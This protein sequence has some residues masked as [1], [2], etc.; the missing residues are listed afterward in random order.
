MGVYDRQVASTLRKLAAKGQLVTWVP[1][2]VTVSGSQPWKTTPV[3]TP[4]TFPVSIVFLSEGSS[5]MDALFHLI[6]GTSV[7][8]GAPRGLMGAVT[9]FTPTMNDTVIRGSVNLTVK[10]IDVVAPNGQ[11]ILYKI[12]FA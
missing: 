1:Q 11:V 8:D 7:P 4:P 12:Q 5:A 9:G 3:S 10:S 6:K 2:D